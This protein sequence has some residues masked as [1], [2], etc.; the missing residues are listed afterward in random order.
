MFSDVITYSPLVSRMILIIMFRPT[1][2]T[3]D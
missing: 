2:S 3:I 1:I